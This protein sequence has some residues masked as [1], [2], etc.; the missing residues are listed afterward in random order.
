MPIFNATVKVKVPCYYEAEVNVE[1]NTKEEAEQKIR[2]KYGEDG[3]DFDEGEIVDIE[4]D[5][6]A[7]EV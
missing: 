6:E 7:G 5:E 4:F 1:A 2:E 3:I